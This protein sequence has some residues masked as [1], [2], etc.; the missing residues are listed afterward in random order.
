MNQIVGCVFCAFAYLLICR[1]CQKK[2]I[3]YHLHRPV[4]I[5]GIRLAGSGNPQIIPVALLHIL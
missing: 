3:A 5:P 2:T 4:Y 1:K